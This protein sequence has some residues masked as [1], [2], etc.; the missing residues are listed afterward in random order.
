MK[1]VSYYN[2]FSSVRNLRV[3]ALPHST[4]TWPS[5][6][7]HCCC[8]S[9]LL[10]RSLLF[11]FPSHHSHRTL[12]NPSGVDPIQLTSRRSSVQPPATPQ[13]LR[14]RTVLHSNS[15]A[16]HH[17]VVTL[18]YVRAQPGC[19]GNVQCDGVLPPTHAAGRLP[20]CVPAEPERAKRFTHTVYMLYALSDFVDQWFSRYTII[21][22]SIVRWPSDNQR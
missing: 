11:V 10:H 3:G 2:R 13:R 19:A 14:L 21:C 1:L 7:L 18:Q 20:S 22:H 6:S 8:S 9:S 4:G 16:T 17:S 15:A 5:I 12:T